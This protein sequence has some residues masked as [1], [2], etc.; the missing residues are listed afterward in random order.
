MALSV[1]SLIAK[2]QPESDPRLEP[3]RLGA[4]LLDAL[5]HTPETPLWTRD[6]LDEGHPF[7]VRLKA[8]IEAGLLTKECAEPLLV[9]AYRSLN[10]DG[11]G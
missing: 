2:E 10:E 6:L 8:E 3:E 11:S 5:L 9:A 7:F 1:R 4:H